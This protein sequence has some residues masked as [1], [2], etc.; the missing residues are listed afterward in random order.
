MTTEIRNAYRND[1]AQSLLDDIQQQRAQYHSFI[2]KVN[3]WVTYPDLT[4]DFTQ[5][6]ETD[7]Y[8]TLVRENALILKKILSSDVSLASVRYDWFV[9]T[10]YTEWDSTKHMEGEP[11][12]VLTTALNVYKCL[13]NNRGS[14][15]TQEPMGKSFG[16]IKTT[17]GYLW[18]YMFS[19]ANYKYNKFADSEFI[20]VQNANSNKFYNNGSVEYVNVVDGG[21]WY[22]STLETQ[23]VVTGATVGSGA[24][25]QILVNASG[26]ITGFTNIVGGSQ[27]VAGGAVTFVSTSGIGAVLTPTFSAG[28]LTGF[29]I[30]DGGLH[31]SNGET[32]TITVGGAVLVPTISASGNIKSV[33]IVNPGSGYLVKPTLTV[34]STG[35]GGGKYGNPTAVVD[36]FVGDGSI[37]YVYVKDPGEG[38]PKNT[39]TTISVSGDGTGAQFSPVVV[40]GKII[41]VNVDNPGTGYTT[42]KLTAIG[43][44]VDA[45]LTASMK[46]ADYT[47]DQSIVEQTAVKGAVYNV[48]VTNGGNNYTSTTQISFVGDGSGFVA[49]PVIVDGSIVDIAITSYGAGYSYLDVI[50]TD[51]NRGVIGTVVDAKLYSIISPGNGHGSDAV[52]ELLATQL[53]LNTEFRQGVGDSDLVQDYRQYGIFKNLTTPVSEKIFTEN[54]TIVAYKVKLAGAVRPV[55]DEVLIQDSTKVKYRVAGILGDYIYLQIMSRR[56]LSPSGTLIAAADGSRLYTVADVVTKPTVNKYSGKLLYVSNT[57]KLLFTDTQG[58][59]IKTV[60]KF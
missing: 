48:K 44:G 36:C 33:T 18:K 49:T 58:I 54:S 15:S 52:A 53:V 32:I 31:Y 29:I 40:G 37:Q 50:L 14:A 46:L 39:L 1:F 20:P 45:K 24:S 25:A 9:G 55:L 17:D 27:Y 4:T 16:V 8:N 35:F 47:S 28:Q 42:I 41:G 23:I 5:G 60:L 59:V 38:Y 11:F 22:S 26:Q 13:S 51:P 12:Y 43:T 2:G 6:P 7:S 34:T 19:I 21:S 57:Q 30:L 3:D 56:V 10:V